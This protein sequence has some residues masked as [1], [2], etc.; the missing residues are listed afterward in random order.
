MRASLPSFSG[1]EIVAGLGQEVSIGFDQW[2]RPYVQASTLEDA[3]FGQ[4]WLHAKN[5]L[6]QM[7]LFRRAGSGRLAQLL[8]ESMLDADKELW[9]FGVPQLAKRLE[10]NASAEMSALVDAYLAGVN[11]AVD[12]YRIL[13]PEFLLLQHRVE[14]WRRADVFALGA[15]MAFQSGNNFRNEMLRLALRA[16]VSALDFELFTTD[17]SAGEDFPFVLDRD[18]AQQQVER[19]SD[20]DKEHALLARGVAGVDASTLLASLDSMS[21]TDPATN[22]GMPRLRF[23]S[24]GWVVAPGKSQS[25]HALYAFD[26]HDQLGLPNLFY[27]V[28]LFFDNGRQIRGWSVAGLPG[29]INGYNE[30]IAWGFTN[31]GDTQDLFIE[32]RSEQQPQLFLDGEDWYEARIETVHIPIKGRDEPEQLQIMHTRNGPLVSDE[33]PLSLSWTAHHIGQRGL[34]SVFA[35]NLARNWQEFN[36]ALD[37]HPAPTLNA[38]YADVHGTIGFRTAGMLPRRGAGEGLFP[39]PG[40]TPGNRWQGFVEPGDMPRASNPPTGFLAAANARV[41]PQGSYPLVSADNAAPYRI[42]RIQDYLQQ[43]ERISAAD[44]QSLQMDWYDGQAAQLLPYLLAEL[45]RETLSPPAQEAVL[46]LQAWAARPLAS[47]DSE[48]ALIFQQWYMDIAREVFVPS[49]GDELYARLLRRSY[50]LNHALDTL[51]VTDRFDSWWPDTAGKTL[52]RA[53]DKTVATLTATTGPAP[54]N[55]RLDQHQAVGLEHELS[56]AVPLLRH[57]FA[58]PSMPWGGS[59]STVGRASYS[60][61]RPFEVTHG[62][63]VRA[64]GE[65]SDTPRLQSVIPGGQSGHP[66]SDHYDDQFSAWREGDLLPISSSPGAPFASQLVL[67]PPSN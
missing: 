66:L 48:A 47:R 26:S 35:F 37:L 53:L 36:D 65:M 56:K 60:Y 30:N 61:S 54:A 45:E 6:W 22:P 8:G 39:L 49:L 16:Q 59:T 42:R 33:P 17:N 24:N 10:Q 43:Q 32:T 50:P 55:W 1:T 52:A 4:G 41:A 51:I 63:T 3:L 58:A 13:P 25:G 44:M 29:V 67:R 64:V 20:S 28:H 15:L 57:L 31:I 7:E 11:A 2:Q 27:E 62:A 9:R 14:R 5:R 46:S 12:G 38:T 34:D 40:N 18:G 19:P 23:G 21:M